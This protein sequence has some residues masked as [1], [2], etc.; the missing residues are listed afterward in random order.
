MIQQSPAVALGASSSLLPSPR[1]QTGD[2]PSLRQDLYPP[3]ATPPPQAAL[4]SEQLQENQ[5][6]DELHH[7][8]GAVL[9]GGP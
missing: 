6:D 8:A 3:P 5:Q 2:T 4:Q 9:V 7:S 1:A